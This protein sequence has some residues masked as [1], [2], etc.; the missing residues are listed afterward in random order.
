M[1][2]NKY[3]PHML[4]LPEDDA[5]RQIAN[6]FLNCLNVNNSAIQI[7]PPAKG[8]SSALEKFECDYYPK[9]DTYPNRRILLL[10]DFDSNYINRIEHVH[11][12]IP[13]NCKE[14]VFVLGVATEPERLK[15][16]LNISYEKIGETLTKDCPQE[17]SDLWKN[18][19]LVHNETELKR[20]VNDVKSFIFVKE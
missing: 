5:N 15:S 16:K 20:M 3:E 17:F 9:M 13:D 12:K 1:S 6:G 2:V 11:K 18:E 14:R 8:W 4:I 7:L 10:I 19:L